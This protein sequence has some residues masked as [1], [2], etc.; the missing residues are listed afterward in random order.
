MNNLLE[1]IITFE[2]YSLKKEEKSKYFNEILKQLTSH[3]FK[4]CNKYKQILELLNFEIL[5]NE[6]YLEIPSL[7]VRLFKNYELHSVNKESIIKTMTSS[8]TSGQ[9]VSKIF[10]DKHTATMQTKVLTKIVADFIGK[11]R[12]PM[13]IIDSKM[14]LKDRKKFSARGAGILGFTMFGHNV[15]YALDEN[16]EIDFEVVTEFC[17]KYKDTPILIFGFTFIIW[18]YLYK[19][20]LASNNKIDFSNAIMIHGGGWKKI[21]NEAVDKEEFK[22]KLFD[23]L[24]IKKIYN[25]YGM[26]E[27]TGS[28][29]MECEYGR[30]HCSNFSDIKFKT[31]NFQ[32]CKVKE[33]GL[34]ELYSVLPY[35]YPGHVLLTEDYGELLGE[36]DCKCGRHGKYFTIDG[37]VKNA[38]IR[39]CSNTYEKES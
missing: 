6:N 29:F 30:F 38:E 16:M 4:E 28:I 10:L 33:K 8:G 35:S 26:I 14:V 3:H 37:R 32:E 19:A 1:K 17:K 31:S 25:Y 21:E 24:N 9:S 27:Q 23:R 13:L 20:L 39:G 34:I 15:T 11:K 12:L 7:P 22:D 2:P 36:D 5:K 18:E